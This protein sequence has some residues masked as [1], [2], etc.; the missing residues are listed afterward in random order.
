[1]PVE[2][3]GEDAVAIANEVTKG[4]IEVEGVSELLESPLGVWVK[5]DS[6]VDDPTPADV[7]EHEDV[8]REAEEV[9]GNDGEEV[10]GE[11]GALAGL[12][13]NEVHPAL[14]A[15]AKRARATPEGVEGML[16]PRGRWRQG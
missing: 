7:E 12:E 13:A 2:R 15:A 11:D 6:D 16:C 9:E 8:E 3:F 1:M 4:M 10:A 5:G 14:V